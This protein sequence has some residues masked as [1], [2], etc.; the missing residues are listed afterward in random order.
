MRL[1]VLFVLTSAEAAK[2]SV[3]VERHTP[4]PLHPPQSSHEP[5]WAGC[6]HL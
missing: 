2:Y 6:Y 1:A 3:R 5:W 4:R